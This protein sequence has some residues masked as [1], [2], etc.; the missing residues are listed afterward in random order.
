MRSAYV[1]WTHGSSLSHVIQ[2]GYEQKAHRRSETSAGQA[3]G[4][5]HP[6]SDH[7]LLVFGDVQDGTASPEPAMLVS[8]RLIVKHLV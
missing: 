7:F 3:R 4:L 8:M 5:L 6:F 2:S 1:A